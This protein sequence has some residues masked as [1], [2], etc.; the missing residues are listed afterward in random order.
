MRSSPPLSDPSVYGAIT[1]PLLLAKDALLLQNY[2]PGT[3]SSGITPAWSLAVEVVFYMLLPLLALV[4]AALAV[5]SA[6]L[7]RRVT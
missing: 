5:R 1:T 3:L 7:R 2:A 6:S 4:A